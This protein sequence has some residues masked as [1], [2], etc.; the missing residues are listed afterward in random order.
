M[1]QL[2]TVCILGHLFWSALLVHLPL[3]QWAWPNL[4]LGLYCTFWSH[5]QFVNIRS[6]RDNLSFCCHLFITLV[7]SKLVF[8]ISLKYEQQ[9]ELFHWNKFLFTDGLLH[10]EN[11]IKIGERFRSFWH[12]FTNKIVPNF[13]YFRSSWP[14]ERDLKQ[15]SRALHGINCAVLIFLRE[16][17]RIWRQNKGKNKK[18]KRSSFCIQDNL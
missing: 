17:Q 6:I 8:Y 9:N 10:G 15:L 1:R 7:W 18:I 16:T 4:D 3:A 11:K 13:I 2:P 14:M 12:I 5:C